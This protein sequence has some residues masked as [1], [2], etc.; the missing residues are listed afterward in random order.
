V[1]G[2]R[3]AQ[4]GPLSLL[5]TNRPRRLLVGLERYQAIGSMDY[6][7]FD[8]KTAPLI[9]TVKI[10]DEDERNSWLASISQTGA[11]LG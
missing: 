4:G 1:H 3:H 7:F 5:L 11:R 8:P 6:G 2:V 9:P 10:E